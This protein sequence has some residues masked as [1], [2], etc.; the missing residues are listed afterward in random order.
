MSETTTTTETMIDYRE[1]EHDV[2]YHCPHCQR[3][4]THH[5]LR[6][7]ADDYPDGDGHYHTPCRFFFDP[8]LK[9]RL[10]AC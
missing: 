5:D 7:A 9:V 8:G 1:I 3:V 2:Q 6:D 4:M 10:V